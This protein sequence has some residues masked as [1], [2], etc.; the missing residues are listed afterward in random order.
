[1]DHDGLKGMIG[2]ALIGSLI[3]GVLYLETS[4][5]FP[6]PDGKLTGFAIYLIL[7]WSFI[8]WA[9][10]AFRARACPACGDSMGRPHFPQGEGPGPIL[11]ECPRCGRVTPYEEAVAT[12]RAGGPEQPS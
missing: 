6:M 1:M 10:S 8:G 7:L 4:Y 5:L 11:Y 12:E 2:G 3:V 9:C